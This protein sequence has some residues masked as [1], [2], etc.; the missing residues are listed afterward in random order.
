MWNETTREESAIE[1]ASSHSCPQCHIIFHGIPT[2]VYPPTYIPTYLG[3]YFRT[4]LYLLSAVPGS[5]AIQ[6]YVI[7]QLC[8]KLYSPSHPNFVDVVVSRSGSPCHLRTRTRYRRYVSE[9]S[10]QL[11]QRSDD[12]PISLDLRSQFDEFGIGAALI[13]FRS[14]CIL[15]R[16]LSK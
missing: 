6:I 7:H 4:R 15:F 2:P 14:S 8:G 13:P 3:S 10:K 11:E 5:S 12:Y 1:V 9:F 16:Y